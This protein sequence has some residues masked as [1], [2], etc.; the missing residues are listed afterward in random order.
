MVAQKFAKRT[1]TGLVVHFLRPCVADCIITF[2][3][4]D[5]LINIYF[6]MIIALE[7][8]ASESSWHDIQKS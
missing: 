3:H 1:Q 6:F 8:S 7:K 5:I 4:A 2:S